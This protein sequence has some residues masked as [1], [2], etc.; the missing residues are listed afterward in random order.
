MQ[1]HSTK[2]ARAVATTALLVL[3]ATLAAGCENDAEPAATPIEQINEDDLF[4]G[5][6]K[7]GQRLEV[8]AQVGEVLT[9]QAFVLVGQDQV[10]DKRVLVVT[11][12]PKPEV[13]KGR[14]VT[15]TGTVHQ[16]DVE[17]FRHRFRLEPPGKFEVFQD[18]EFLVASRVVPEEPGPRPDISRG[19]GP[20]E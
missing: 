7:V 12:Q 13:I 16:F 15:V 17:T 8:N 11:E 9:P 6:E 4:D 18:E 14:V 1:P 19:Y 20:P 3:P 5:D 2:L 10:G